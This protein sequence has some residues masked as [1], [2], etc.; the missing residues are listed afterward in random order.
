MVDNNGMQDWAADYNGEGGERVSRD[1]GDSEVAMMT[2][3]VGVD[4]NGNG[5]R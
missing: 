2:A 5:G 4:N 1:G 3:V